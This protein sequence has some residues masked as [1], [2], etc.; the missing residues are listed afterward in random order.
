MKYAKF[1]GGWMSLSLF[2]RRIGLLVSAIVLSA[3]GSIEEVLADDFDNCM[4]AAGLP[5]TNTEFEVQGT[6]VTGYRYVDWDTDYPG[7][8][9]DAMALDNRSNECLLSVLREHNVHHNL[10]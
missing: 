6:Q 10:P 3:C 4:A 7:E 1:L 5:S 2:W 9:T 8:G